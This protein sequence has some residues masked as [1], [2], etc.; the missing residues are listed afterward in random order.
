MIS[1][2]TFVGIRHGEC[3]EG[4]SGDTVICSAHCYLVFRGACCFWGVGVCVLQ[5]GFPSIILGGRA[6][7]VLLAEATA[8]SSASLAGTSYA[9]LTNMGTI[10]SLWVTGG[11]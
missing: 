1:V 5:S 4:T 6:N 10:G 9:A 7:G 11:G 8:R 3:N 2:L